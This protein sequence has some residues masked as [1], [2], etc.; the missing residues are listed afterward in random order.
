MAS[1]ALSSSL[2]EVGE[3]ERE[4]RVEICA[5]LSLPAGGL[6]TDIIIS[7]ATTNGTAGGLIVT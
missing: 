4:G 2:Y 6:E 7:L 3:G 1:V 5:S